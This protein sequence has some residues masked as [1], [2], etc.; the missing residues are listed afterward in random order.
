MRPLEQ[1]LAAPRIWLIK[2]EPSEYSIDDLLNAPDRILPWYG[3]RNYQARNFIRDTMEIGDAVLFYHSSCPQPGI[4]GFAKICSTS[5]IDEHQFDE[6]DPYYDPKSKRENPRW[7][8]I[9]IQGICRV[10]IIELKTMRDI[11]RLHTMKVLQRGNRLS[12]SPVT[13]EE[14]RLL[15][16]HFPLP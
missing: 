15:A 7:Y 8:S 16:Q 2:S 11:P 4:V 13:H 5:Y 12:I 10:P 14:L 1:L 3:I 6:K 9:D